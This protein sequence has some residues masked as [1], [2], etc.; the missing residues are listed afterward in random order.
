MKDA[1]YWV[2]RRQE[3]DV[4]C[5]GQSF[6]VYLH[7]YPIPQLEPIKGLFFLG[8]LEH[9]LGLCGSLFVKL[10]SLASVQL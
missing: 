5:L 9:L 1:V 2:G 10:N 4:V 3:D 6:L 8:T 7:L